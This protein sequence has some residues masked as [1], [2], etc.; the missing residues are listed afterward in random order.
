MTTGAYRVAHQLE[1]DATENLMRT[2]TQ[3]GRQTDRK[4]DRQTERLKHL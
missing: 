3:A 4:I 2:Y 1:L